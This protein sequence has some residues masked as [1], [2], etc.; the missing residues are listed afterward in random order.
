MFGTLRDK[1]FAILSANTL[2][3]EVYNYEAIQFEGDP[4]AVLSP[5]G[6]EGDYST[7][8]MNERRYAF[9]IRLFVSRTA[10]EDKNA[11]LSGAKE[12]DRVLVNL[13]DS[14]IDD[15][16]KDYTFSGL[17]VPTGYCMI[18]VFATPSSWGYAGA[19]D[20]YRVA[21][22]VITCRVGVDVNAIS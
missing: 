4:V 16:D 22:I 20:E 5:S 11:G 10:R 12:A 17:T 3:Q 1:I 7:T 2:I 6:N 19:E 21:E 15:F 8:S 18:N 14:V 13:V 9:T